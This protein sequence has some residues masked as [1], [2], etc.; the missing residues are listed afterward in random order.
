MSNMRS[1][2]KFMEETYRERVHLFEV[3]VV[4]VAGIDHDC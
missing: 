2:V 3:D 1:E 4:L